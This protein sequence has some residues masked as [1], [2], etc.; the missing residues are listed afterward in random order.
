MSKAS[1][2]VHPLAAVP[3]HK[4]NF[5]LKSVSNPAEELLITEDNPKYEYVAQNLG[6]IININGIGQ[7]SS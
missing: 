2:T 7:T 3:G 5:N 1:Y 6:R 4:P